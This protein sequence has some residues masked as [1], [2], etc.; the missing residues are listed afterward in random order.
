[1]V[2]SMQCFNY[3]ERNALLCWDGG[4]IVWES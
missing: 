4:S 3:G 1:M 2:Y